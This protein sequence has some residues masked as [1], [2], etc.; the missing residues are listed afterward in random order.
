MDNGP[1]TGKDMFKIVNMFDKT[2]QLTAFNAF[3]HDDN[4]WLLLNHNDDDPFCLWK[5]MSSKFK[6]LPLVVVMVFNFG[7]L[8]FLN[9]FHF[10][11]FSR[12]CVKWHHPN[13]DWVFCHEFGRRQLE[14]RKPDETF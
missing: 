2:N 11:S 8:T 6:M 10:P 9:S 4:F 5:L 12:L 13:Q 7:H 1:F 3:M 14:K